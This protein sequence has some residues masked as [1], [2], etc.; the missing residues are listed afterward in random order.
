M[1]I[2]MG[3]AHM[4]VI[5]LW[6][7]AFAGI[8][9][10][11]EG[12]SPEHLSFL[13]LL[14]GSMALVCYGAVIKMKLPEIKDWPVIF[15]FGFLGFAVYQTALSFGELTVSAGAASLLVSTSP[16]FIGLLGRMFFQERTGKWYW[17]GASISMVGIF[18]ISFGAGGGLELGIGVLFILIASLSESLYFVF[19]K[20]YLDKYGALP[21]TA[22]TIW[23]ATIFMAFFSPGIV[24]QIS[25]AP[26]GATIS[27]IYL[28]LFPTVI[29]Y[30][31]IAYI[32]AQSGAS[33]AASSLYLTPAA[34][35][36]IA[37]IWLGEVPGIMTIAGGV[38]TL[39]GVSLTYF[40]GRS[41]MTESSLN[42]KA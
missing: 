18:F 21:F 32:T 14:V 28:G 10:G 39:I 5:L 31:A 6:G 8:R 27:A 23:A 24:S 36:L 12:Y 42:I 29:A 19:Q 35:F 11:L 17:S 3:A 26:L 16:V 4:L 20:D 37:W 7:S 41:E 38:I 25:E 9:H 1:N 33:E 15:L 22:Y 30:F 13:R 40:K 2:R 34:S